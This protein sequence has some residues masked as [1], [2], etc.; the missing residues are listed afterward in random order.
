MKG[1]NIMNKEKRV[2]IITIGLMS[3]ILACVMFMQFKVVNETDIAE[4]ESMR[5]DELQEALSSWKE[6][7][8]EIDN[9]LEDTE[10]KIKEYKEK[11]ES[12][13]ETN[14]LVEKELE[15][16]NIILGKTDVTGNG[17]Q[18]VL[19]DND[20]QEYSALDSLNLINEL[21]AA[22]AEAISINGERVINLTDIVDISNRY[23]LVNSNKISSPYTIL[24]IGDENYLKSALSIKNGYVDIKQK[25]GYT[26][27]I[28]SKNNLK[29]NKYSKE[30]N[31]KYIDI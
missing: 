25:E 31:L 29:I 12:S 8:T 9:K 7:Y 24:A 23:I 28:E 6:K 17:I 26:I 11:S 10:N 16:A 22:G 13:E 30:I 3:L 20:N 21:R 19:T 2:I 4:I 15:E 27:S 14:K 5:E 18:I 1:R